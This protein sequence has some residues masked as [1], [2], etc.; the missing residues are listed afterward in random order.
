MGDFL[1]ITLPNKQ[2]VI[3]FSEP[4]EIFEIVLVG[5]T[6]GAVLGSQH[7]AKINIGKSDSPNGVVRFVNESVITVENPDSTLK[8]S[9]MLKREGGFLGNATVN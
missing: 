2:N 4:S 1:T 5:A 3:F 7:V 8:L 6:G 9:L